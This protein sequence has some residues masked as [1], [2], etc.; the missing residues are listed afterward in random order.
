MADKRE[1]L[2]TTIRGIKEISSKISTQM[3]KDKRDISD[4]EKYAALE[5][6]FADEHENVKTYADGRLDDIEKSLRDMHRGSHNSTFEYDSTDGKDIVK[7][8][9]NEDTR[10]TLKKMVDT[11]SERFGNIEGA[12]K[13]FQEHNDT[14]M[15]LS[16]VCKRAP[17]DLKYYDTHIRKNAELAKAINPDGAAT[18]LEW[19]PTAFSS[20]FIESMEQEYQVAGTIPKIA[21]PQ[22]SDN[23]KI[24]AAGSNIS[25]V[26]YA[27]TAGDPATD[28]TSATPGSRQITLNPKKMAIMVQVEE[29]SLEDSIVNVIQDI[30][31]PEMQK[32]AARG[33]DDAIINGNGES[34][35]GG[36]ALA[37]ASAAYGANDPRTAWDGLRRYALD[38]A[39][40]NANVNAGGDVITLADIATAAATFADQTADGGS[41]ALQNFYDPANM[42]LLTDLKVYLDLMQIENVIQAQMI[43]SA[44]AATINSGQ[45]M[46]VM[47]VPII[48]TQLVRRTLATGL[49]HAS[50][51]NALHNAVLFNTQAFLLG[52]KRE[53]TV[54][55]R[56]N[57]ETDRR[58]I[59]M[60][61][62]HDFVSRYALT[63]PVAAHIR[64][65]L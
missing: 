31:I 53:V 55:S 56:E 61:M 51:G 33:I 57:I 49:L 17:Q 15:V 65:I 37:D 30:T 41:G 63:A 14:L 16:H 34:M 50:A 12:V 4:A 27:A 24:P 20:N 40:A 11:P 28:I 59:V 26:T 29:E 58:H 52:T 3:E 48:Q 1:A 64:N 5:K 21:I 9:S 7:N 23:L 36:G 62:R 19:V 22:G 10:E 54:K 13:E 42:R 47:G 44:T 35:T 45:L 39:Y 43:G 60:T 25:V 18:G 46:S 8:A 6:K 2:N 38:T 32:A